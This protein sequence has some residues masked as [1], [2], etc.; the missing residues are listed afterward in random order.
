MGVGIIVRDYEKKVLAT[1]CSSRKFIINPIVTE[2]Y[3][4]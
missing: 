1:M 3:A 2:A 4:A